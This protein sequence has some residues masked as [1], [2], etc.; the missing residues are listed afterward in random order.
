MVTS[1]KDRQAEPVGKLHWMV[2]ALIVLLTMGM[3]ALAVRVDSAGP[4][5]PERNRIFDNLK[6]ID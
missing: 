6:S 2:I 3:L 5:K 4:S 1:G